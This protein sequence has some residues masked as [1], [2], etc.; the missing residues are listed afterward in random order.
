MD[1]ATPS[2]LAMLAAP[3]TQPWLLGAFAEHE[4]PAPG[5]GPNSASGSSVSQDSC[6][7][8]PTRSRLREP[9]APRLKSLW[10]RGGKTRAC[11]A[12]PPQVSPACPCVTRHL[13]FSFRCYGA[14]WPLLPG[15]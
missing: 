4:P 10:G 15:A 1:S 11:Q 7:P 3:G 6:G 8:L 5:Q 9:P 12:V 14:A 13:A 2:K